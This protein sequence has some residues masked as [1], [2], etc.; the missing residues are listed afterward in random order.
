[1][2]VQFIMLKAAARFDRFSGFQNHFPIVVSP[3]SSVF[4]HQNRRAFT[5]EAKWLTEANTENARGRELPSLCPSSV[6]L[7]V[8]VVSPSP[9]P[10]ACLRFQ[11][12][13]LIIANHS[14]LNISHCRLS[15]SY[16]SATMGSRRVAR[17]EGR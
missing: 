8:S 5:T 1:M 10:Q 15:H 13:S 11:T 16:L 17:R 7:C 14:S 4:S 3:Q 12:P 9:S 2:A 6:I